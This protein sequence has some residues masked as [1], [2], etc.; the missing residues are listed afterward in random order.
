MRTVFS[1][2]IAQQGFE[3]KGYV[4]PLTPK[5]L[6]EELGVGNDALEIP[7]WSTQMSFKAEI[8]NQ[9][10]LS[11]QKIAVLVSNEFEGFSRNG[12]IGTYY[13]T[14][15]QK[16]AV[17][18]WTIVLL[19]C[20]TEA[21]FQGGSHFGTV[22]H[23]FST[24]ET[25]QVL[26]LRLIHQQILSATQQFDSSD[27]FDYQSF[28]CLFF[29][30][31]IEATFPDAVIYAEFPEIW[32]FGY[33]TI[34][35]KQSGWLGT[36]CLIGVTSHGSFEWLQE[37][38]S[39]YRTEQP[40]WLWQA[41]HYEQFSY[42]NA[43]ITYSPSHF[44]KSKLSDY[45]W[46][47]AHV[48]HLPYF[49]PS[50]TLINHRSTASNEITC[51]K[52]PVIF[53]GRLEE[54]KGLC[55][56]LEAVRLIDSAIAEKIHIIFIGKVIPLQS[57][58]LQHLDSQQYIDR[59]LGDS[60]TYTLLSDL[61][62]QEAIQA[63]ANLQ[64]P[65]VCL[66]SLQENFPNAALEVGQLSV[67]LVLSDTGGFCETLDLLQRSNAVRWFQPGNA[68]ALAQTLIQAIHAYPEN[69]PAFEQTAVD[70]INRHLLNQ[71][72]ELMSQAF[73]EAA[74]K[75]RT[76]PSVTIVLVCQHSA[77]TLL[78]CLKSLTAQTYDAFDVIVAS[79]TI[80]EAIQ[81]AIIQAQTQFSQY[82]YLTADANW[83]LGETYNE[84]VD[85]SAGEYILFF[86]PDQI[87]TPSMV[88]KMVAAACESEA[89]A[90]VC[91]QWVE[92]ETISL[93][94]GN[95]LKLLEFN[96]RHDLTALFSKT[97]LQSF[98]YT[99]ER[100]L[101]ALNW[102]I[103]AAAIAIDQSIAYY[104][105]PL[106]L[107]LPDS[108]STISSESLAK[109]RYYLRQYLF[110]IKPEQ[111]NQRQIN[112][113]LTGFEH[114]VQSPPQ[115]Q[116]SSPQDQAWM[117][118]AEQLQHEL[119]QAQA[120]LK[121]LEHWNQELQ[122][123]KDW[124]QSQLTHTQTH[125]EK[126]KTWSQEL[127]TGKDWLES[128]WQ[129]WMLRTQKAEGEGKQL[130][131][132]IQQM[133]DS[134]FW[135]LRQVW[136]KLKRK[137]SNISS[138]PF[139]P[140]AH[141]FTP[142][143][144][145]FVSRIAGQKIRYFQSAATQSPVVSIVSSCSGKSEYFETT[146]RSII[147]QTLQNFEWIIVDDGSPDPETKALLTALSHR[148]AKIRVIPHT[149]HRGT[150]ASYNTAIAQS[151]GKYLCFIDFG[152]I[153]DPTYLEKCVLFLETHSQVSVV[154][155]YS[156][157][158]QAQEHW[159]KSHLKQPAALF[160][161]NTMMSHPLYRRTGFDQ[162]GGFDEALL[163]RADWD[164]CLKALTH[165][166]FGWTIPEFLDCYRIT[167]AFLD[168]Q[169]LIETIRS[170]YQTFF[171]NS[172]ELDL[173][174]QP[175]K[176]DALNFKLNLENQCDLPEPISRRDRSRP[177][178][179]V[180]LFCEALD[181][182]EVAQW[183]CDLVIWLAKCGYE[184]T[185]ATT[186]PSDHSCQEFFYGAT[187]DIFHLPNLFERS[188]W[189]AVVR[190]LLTARQID[191]VLVSG[192]DIA[193]SF[194][195]LLKIEFPN[196]VLADYAHASSAIEGKEFLSTRPE[197]LDYQMVAFHRQAREYT[198]SHPIF[199]SKIKV[200]PTQ[201]AVE[202]ALSEA[203]AACQI[204]VAE[205]THAQLKQEAL[206]LLLEGLQ[207]P[208]APPQPKFVEADASSEPTTRQLL[209]LLLKKLVKQ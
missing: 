130:R 124:L 181:S 138:D 141:S 114:L 31:A 167:N 179:R 209:K 89:V 73:L 185:I 144:Q 69:P 11:T 207:E 47:T 194:L 94:D 42:E 105:Y 165:D 74:P 61:S 102:Q 67:S 46:K 157:V 137:L 16:L 36:S 78:E 121:E 23:V 199:K 21:Q 64:H 116:P 20:Q 3:R 193:Y 2:K 153:L 177:G 126:L 81:A 191:G 168:Q 91:P 123:G 96:H 39:R 1:A 56:F 59:E 184:V 90:V 201:L 52:I 127:Q 139:Q 117:L 62:S 178:K 132:L 135:K 143:I 100:G 25:T 35:A 7:S 187:P 171:A 156:I 28:C 136:L 34:Q 22:H 155:S 146:Y 40:D 140:A 145:E 99:Q 97:L 17:D 83:S 142:G 129:I 204:T 6:I 173:D 70:Q 48:K 147:N 79:P 118:T 86:S 200:C 120:R 24:H 158:F 122:T 76:K 27:R 93:V 57:S 109:E 43:D 189:L 172:L 170:R 162:L 134:K 55:T 84:L 149:T 154:N 119:T 95:L 125:L 88:E 110:Q 131:S 49:V 107:I 203:I 68:H 13:K 101:Q 33:R 8:L 196:I 175:L 108:P 5:R 106:Y 87:A 163:G 14:L 82:K 161:Q 180:L 53:F 150:A 71:R 192:S 4:E 65:I 50:L 174:S 77:I 66:T 85:Q 92:P 72:L 176:L 190:Y 128:Q 98:R 41:Y 206:E 10:N 186:S 111:W 15:S 160:Q 202:I 60:F 9:F 197:M 133:Q 12:G 148:T 169:Q 112:L 198:S 58:Y 37:I 104:P 182:S 151:R 208:A 19:L 195:P 45:G 166:Q 63:I 152:G 26:N 205:P 164:R 18:G 159:W 38:N 188:Y 75:Q 103:F 30:Q 51:N 183:N 29:M 54:R 115:R 32:G 113:L 80:D 44:L